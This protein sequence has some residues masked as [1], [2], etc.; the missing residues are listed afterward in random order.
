M[1]RLPGVGK[2]RIGR[3]MFDNLTSRGG[4]PSLNGLRAFEAM[5]R[6]GSATRAAAELNVTHSAVSRQVKGLEAALG[7][8]LFEGPRHR[9]TL[10]ATGREMLTGLTTGFDALD[11]AV[12]ATRRDREVQVAVNASLAVKWLIPRLPAFERLHPGIAVHLNDLAPHATG[13]RGA[14]LVIRYLGPEAFRRDEVEVLT[15]NRIGPVCTPELAAS[16]VTGV[17]GT[18]LTAR[19]HPSGWTDWSRAAGRPAATGPIRTLAHLHF[20]LDAALAGLGVAVLPLTIVADDLATG[21]L[22]APLGFVPDGGAL[23]AIPS[24]E[25]PV[26]HLRTFL[27]WLRGQA[28]ASGA[29]SAP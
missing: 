12:R 1:R 29:Q 14:D 4:L 25:P 5:G 21:R 28:E 22:S 11:A 13:Q 6:T 15:A 27:D 10:T 3:G 16:V 26:R 7:V 17:I 9:L 8:R 2:R 24:G 20:V 19:T 18:R 23:V